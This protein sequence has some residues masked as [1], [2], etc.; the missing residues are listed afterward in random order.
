MSA[1]EKRKQTLHVKR[2]LDALEKKHRCYNFHH[3][4]EMFVMYAKQYS[5]RKKLSYKAW[6]MV[7]V[8]A[9]ILAKAGI[10][11]V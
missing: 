3:L 7:G 8:P 2:Y 1:V 4:Q 9:E 6:R 11:R 5:D 10:E